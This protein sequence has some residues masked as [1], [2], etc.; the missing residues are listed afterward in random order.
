[1]LFQL[2]QNKCIKI[3]LFYK[4]IPIFQLASPNQ[5]LSTGVEIVVAPVTA[6]PAQGAPHSTRSTGT[7]WGKDL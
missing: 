1:M 2:Q 3:E 4:T 6:N 7:P 5:Y